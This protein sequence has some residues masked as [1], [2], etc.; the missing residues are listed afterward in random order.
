MDINI[1]SVFFCVQ[2]A[3]K[4]MIEIG[5]GSIVLVG[6]AHSWSG[7]K[8]RAAYAISKGALY[9]LSE[10]LSHN[11][12]IDKIRCNFITMGWTPTDGEL[13]LRSKQGMSKDEL[14]NFASSKLPM[15]RMLTAEDHLPAIIYL[16][17]DDSSMVSG[18]N[19]RV[20][21]GEYI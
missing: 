15:G 4:S 18:S 3:I 10:H 12:A 17:S 5:G 13:A 21:A 19:I 14:I 8:D 16:L 2:H 20:T 6:S 9:T 11:Y 1:K 7:Q